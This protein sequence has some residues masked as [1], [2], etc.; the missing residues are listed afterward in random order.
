MTAQDRKA[1]AAEVFAK[2]KELGINT[3]INGHFVVL[4]PCSKVPVS[5]T[6]AAAS[7]PAELIELVRAEQA[8]AK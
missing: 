7:C 1:K 4:S 2:I 3:E 8:E 5:L 6:V